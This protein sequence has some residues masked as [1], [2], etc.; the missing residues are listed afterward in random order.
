MQQQLGTNY[1]VELA[2]VGSQGRNLLLKGDPN[3]APP[4]VGVTNSERQPPVRD[5]RRRRCAAIGQVQSA[6]MLDYNGFLVKLQRRFAN[7]FSVLT[8]YTWNKA[9]DLNSDNDG[10]VTADQRLRPAVQPRPVPTTTSRTP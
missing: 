8:S 7:N 10:Q 1:M 9:N 4:T 6:G 2:Y 3:Q 5:G